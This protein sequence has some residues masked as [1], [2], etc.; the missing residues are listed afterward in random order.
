MTSFYYS[1]CI[2]INQIIVFNISRMNSPYSDK[3][4]KNK[5]KIWENIR[6]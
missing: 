4:D 6:M 1:E 5:S 3:Y 2:Q